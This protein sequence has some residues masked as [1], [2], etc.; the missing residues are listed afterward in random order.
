MPDLLATKSAIKKVLGIVG[1]I[2]DTAVSNTFG[3]STSQVFRDNT[4]KIRNPEDTFDHVIRAGS[5]TANR[6]LSIPLLGANDIFVIQGVTQNITGVK[7]FSSGACTFWNPAF[8]F[9]YSVIPSAITA[10]RNITL[11]LLTGNDVFV[12]ESHTQTL[13]NKT[14]TTPVLTTPTIN[15]SKM[16]DPAT[17]TGAYTLLTTDSIIRADASGSA[18]TLTLPAASGNAGLTYTIIRTDVAFSTNALTVDANASETIDGNLTHILW[19]AESII[20]ECDGTNWNVIKG[21][22]PSQTGYY[23]NKGATANRRYV[24]GLTIQQIALLTSTTAVAVNTLWAMPF[25]VQ[26]P[27]KFDTISAEV[28]TAGA[29]S[30]LRLG[31]YRD[32][33]NLYPGALIFDSGNIS[34]A[35][36][37]VK[38]STITA[39]LQILQPGLYWL[40]YEHSATAPQIRILPGSGYLSLWPPLLGTTIPGYAYSVAHT[41][42]ALP[43]PYT[44]GGTLRTAV[45]A[46]AAAVPAVGLRA[47]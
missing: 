5:I 31:I 17:K 44:A 22:E 4:L 14:L 2:V 39:S 32:N 45:S 28:T 18:F 43:N 29:S 7:R 19:P 30:N 26:R 15:G 23:F 47:V 20:I 33:G 16:A 25:V 24:A 35:T 34:G 46:A 41:V 6:D 38:D 9:V 10:S 11:P 36:T 13:T 12:F 42:G 40:T 1:D 3:A 8:T 37:G 27:T 21:N